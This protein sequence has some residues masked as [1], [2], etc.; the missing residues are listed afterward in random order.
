[1]NKELNIADKILEHFQKLLKSDPERVATELKDNPNNPVFKMVG[2]AIV[3]KAVQESVA[4][5]DRGKK[6][7]TP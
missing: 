2:Q 4:D 1:M 3:E 5:K 7:K 6:P